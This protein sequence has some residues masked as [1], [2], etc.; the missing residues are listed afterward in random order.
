MSINKGIKVE[1]T[2]IENINVKQE[3]QVENSS[4]YDN[5]DNGITLLGSMQASENGKR[6]KKRKGGGSLIDSEKKRRLLEQE[7][8][9]KL[10]FRLQFFYL[11]SVF[12][13]IDI[14][15]KIT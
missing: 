10:M 2:S 5:E 3:R 8:V 7:A 1:C 14:E 6:A 15:I 4:D 11:L 13:L 12:R 9:I